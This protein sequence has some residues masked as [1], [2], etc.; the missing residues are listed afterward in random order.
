MCTLTRETRPD[1]WIVRFN[2]DELHTRPEESPLAVW[3]G[4][5]HRFLAARDGERPSTWLA[6]NDAGLVLA[7]LNDYG[8]AWRAAAPRG[9]RG[10]LVWRLAGAAGSVDDVRAQMPPR[11]SLAHLGAF[12]LFVLT[13]RAAALWRWDG[14]SL[15]STAGVPAMASSSSW[16]PAETVAVR[17]ARFAALG[18]APGSAAL[19]AFHR[20][21]DPAAGAESVCMCRPD[22]CTRS[23]A[24]V[25]VGAGELR[26]R[27][28][29]LSWPRR[30]PTPTPA[31]VEAEL[32]LRQ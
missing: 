4:P 6:A 19:E 26:F 1:C 31:P 24:R 11:E 32:T 2:R 27:W 21:H 8:A 14:E 12:A 28:E 30:S 22:A 3:G 13:G 5:R 23:L 29:P 20:A 25:E 16:R 15:T 10:A 18:P 9:S 7:L 17:A